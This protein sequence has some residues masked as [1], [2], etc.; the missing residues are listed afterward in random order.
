LLLSSRSLPP[1]TQHNSTL[2]R[3]VP[4]REVTKSAQIT[5]SRGPEYIVYVSVFLASIGCNLVVIS[6]VDDI[7]GQRPSCLLRCPLHFLTFPLPGGI[8][9]TLGSAV[10]TPH[11]KPPQ[12]CGNFLQDGGLRFHPRGRQIITRLHDVTAQNRVTFQLDDCAA[13]TFNLAVLHE[14]IWNVYEA[15]DT[16]PTY[17]VCTREKYVTCHLT[18][19]NAGYKLATNLRR[20]L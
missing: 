8:E 18:Q 19:H 14:T 6:L 11:H 9:P 16:V 1:T 12:N 3:R 5:R 13:W 7:C 20:Y 4:S 15:Y 10:P 17:T 2:H